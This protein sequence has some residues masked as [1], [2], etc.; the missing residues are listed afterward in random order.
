MESLNLPR[1]VTC[2][3]NPLRSCPSQVT[4][5]FSSVTRSH[6]VVYCQAIIEKNARQ[7]LQADA[8]E[9]FDNWFPYD[10]YTLPRLVLRTFTGL[11]TLLIIKLA[12]LCF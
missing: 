9:Q 11:K 5:A 10:P 2:S 4:R 1:L 8:G 6:Q 7:T 12:Y 3:L